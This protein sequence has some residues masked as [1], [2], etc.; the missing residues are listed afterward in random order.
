MRKQQR[1]RM[2]S[3]QKRFSLFRPKKRVVNIAEKGTDRS[4]TPAT[5]ANRLLDTSGR[6]NLAMDDELA[7]PESA[8]GYKAPRRNN[9]DNDID[10]THEAMLPTLPTSHEAP[11]RP[12]S[13]GIAARLASNVR[14]SL[15]RVGSGPLISK[16]G[17][18]SHPT[19]VVPF[20]MPGYSGSNN[21]YTHP[22]TQQPSHHQPFSV[23]LSADQM[24]DPV[25]RTRPTLDHINSA[26]PSAWPGYNSSNPP[27]QYH[28]PP[29]SAP[30][31]SN[32]EP[33][34][35]TAEAL[36][37]ARV[38][39]DGSLFVP[40]N[41]A[42]WRQTATGI[43]AKEEPPRPK[44]E[45]LKNEN[46]LLVRTI[47]IERARV[48]R[49]ADPIPHRSDSLDKRPLVLHE[50]PTEGAL[51]KKSQ[52]KHKAKDPLERG[53]SAGAGYSGVASR[54][55]SRPSAPLLS[56]LEAPQPSSSSRP[57]AV[58]LPSPSNLP[59]PVARKA[60]PKSDFSGKATAGSGKEEDDV[61]IATKEILN[62]TSS[63]LSQERN[64]KLRGK[65]LSSEDA[66][67]ESLLAHTSYTGGNIKSE[68][69]RTPSPKVAPSAEWFD[70]F[71]RGTVPPSFT[72]G[73][74]AGTPNLTVGAGG[75]S[76]DLARNN[77]APATGPSKRRGENSPSSSTPQRFQLNPSAVSP[78]PP[79]PGLA[80]GTAFYGAP[81][82]ATY[83]TPPSTSQGTSANTSAQPSTAPA[84]AP[85]TRTLSDTKPVS[86]THGVT[87]NRTVPAPLGARPIRQ[88]PRIPPGGPRTSED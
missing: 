3:Y 17:R 50:P 57:F 61:S 15:G 11:D 9:S 49:D 23:P 52:L 47:S 59:A 53:D 62:I 35:L 66:V 58:P 36:A 2:K 14:R 34:P 30:L 42:R 25:S 56:P 67:R 20:N 85:P 37:A 77:T 8:K 22:M 16:L 69:S 7:S 12:G 19:T 75:S 10:I 74:S 29:N 55:V 46:E 28:Q 39:Q 51:K 88:L 4:R 40:E 68:G 83:T 18:S 33:T 32:E 76:K 24:A 44:H 80:P 38:A 27:Q 5:G 54:N 78:F 45:R 1:L 79:T 84:A 26:P 48:S 41:I 63:P 31:L 64:A 6:V 60:V 21:R 43:P 86:L 65:K 87:L 13:A 71:R 82:A 73:G 72:P 70:L 81:I